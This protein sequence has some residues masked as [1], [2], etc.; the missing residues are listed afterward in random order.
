MKIAYIVFHPISKNDGVVKKVFS[1]VKA[2]E[3]LNHK[4][5]VFAF[6]NDG[7]KSDI[8]K[9]YIYHEKRSNYRFNLNQK[10]IN[11]IVEYNPDK[12]YCRYDTFNRSIYQLKKLGYP[13]I[14]EY[15]TYDI[16]EALLLFKKSLKLKELIKWTLYFFTRK[17]WIKQASGHVFVTKDLLLKYRRHLPKSSPKIAIP[18]SI[19]I[20]SFQIKQ[21]LINKKTSENRIAFIG[22]PNQPWHGLDI[23]KGLSKKLNNIHFDIIGYEGANESNLT[24]HGYLSVDKFF[25]IIANSSACIGPL[26]IHKYNLNQSSPLKV[27]EYI[28]LGAPIIL[29]YNDFPLTMVKDDPLILHLSS[30]QKNWHIEIIDFLNKLKNLE[31]KY[32]ESTLALIDSKYVDKKRVEFVTSI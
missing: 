5:R 10:F 3:S 6:S 8:L 27:R 9:A 29:G 30:N 14:F 4:I 21:A 32:K 2:F 20:E 13:L 22:T 12:I 17:F 26:G 16:S 24:Y 28:V 11:D 18:N 23:I 1:Q 19:L 25:P 15:N 7:K 31:R